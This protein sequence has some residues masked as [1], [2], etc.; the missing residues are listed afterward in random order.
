MPAIG[1]RQR[2]TV[3]ISN[4]FF[5]IRVIHRSLTRYACVSSVRCAVYKFDSDSTEHANHPLE[6]LSLR[7][8]RRLGR[9]L[10]RGRAFISRAPRLSSHHHHFGAF[11]PP[12]VPAT[13]SGYSL[14]FAAT[15]SSALPRQTRA[16]RVPC[17]VFGAPRALPLARAG[18]DIIQVCLGNTRA[19][20][21][22]LY[23]DGPFPSRR[24]AARY[25]SAQLA[26]LP[27]ETD[28]NAVSDAAALDVGAPSTAGERRRLYT[29]C[30]IELRPSCASPC[31]ERLAKPVA[32]N[33]V[34]TSRNCR[35]VIHPSPPHPSDILLFGK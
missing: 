2:R 1:K 14:R 9:D 19:L 29:Q 21:G 26:Q 34:R 17:V 16:A 24:R 3:A 31:H 23:L 18:I 27:L 8:Y 13:Y 11:Y 6:R 28:I 5:D 32:R 20:A 15:L 7:R 30:E 12:K 33:R 25:N 4:C 35:F 22:M 10:S